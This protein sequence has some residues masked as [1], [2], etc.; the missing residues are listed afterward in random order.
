[1]LRCQS[2]S[3]VRHALLA[4]GNDLSLI[5]LSIL[6]HLSLPSSQSRLITPHSSRNPTALYASCLPLTQVQWC[7]HASTFP[8]T[9][10]PS[11]RLF[12]SQMRLMTRSGEMHNT[13]P[14]NDLSNSMPT[15]TSITITKISAIS[16]QPRHPSRP[17]TH[18]IEQQC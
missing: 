7:H 10:T 8:L 4:I 12:L 14:I 6:A 17:D 3:N 15:T 5:F 16:A 13:V 9:L 18:C 11:S 2:L 1:M